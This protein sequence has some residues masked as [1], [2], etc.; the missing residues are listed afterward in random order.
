VPALRRWLPTIALGL[1]VAAGC[2]L[3]GVW[4]WNR[5]VE[6]SAAVAVVQAN[7]SASPVPLGNVVS[8]VH[9]APRADELWRPVAM[10][11][12]YVGGQVLLRNRPVNGQPAF[13]VLAPFEVTEGALGGSVLV[14]DRG[15]V[16]TAEDASSTPDLPDV[17]A[18]TVQVVVRLRADEHASRRDAPAAQVQA[19]S[20]GQVL[21]AAGLD[22][23]TALPAYGAVVSEAGERPSGLGALP[24]PSTDPGP[25]LSYAFQW[26]VFA[27]GAVGGCIVL[28]RRDAR[29]DQEAAEASAAGAG[30]PSSTGPRTMPGPTR[31]ARGGRRPTAE[32]EED[33][34]LDAQQTR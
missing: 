2:V 18:G 32:Q 9:D 20:S 3:A 19:I 24:L 15:W 8:G 6:R 17:P 25:H 33:A 21:T 16:P 27:V 7:Y 13:H 26:W 31:P 11:G 12:R 28:I 30:A 29:Q 4:Q 22:P 34:L 5:H 1:A 23:A 14:V 10:T